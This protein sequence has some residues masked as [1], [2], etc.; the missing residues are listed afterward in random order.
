ME[1]RPIEGTTAFQFLNSKTAA[2]DPVVLE[3]ILKALLEAQG[4]RATQ[5]HLPPYPY[6]STGINA[7]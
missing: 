6:L 7:P 5:E 1:R 2:L 4:E 3:G